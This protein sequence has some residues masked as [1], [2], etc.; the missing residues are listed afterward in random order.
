MP[1]PS[2]NYS[3]C[4][5]FR[6]C[7]GPVWPRRVRRVRPPHGLLEAGPVLSPGGPRGPVRAGARPRCPDHP[8]VPADGELDLRVHPVPVQPAGAGALEGPPLDAV[9]S[10]PLP[11]RVADA[12][13]PARERQAV[14]TRGAGGGGA[15][16]L[17]QPLTGTHS[18]IPLPATCPA[19]PP[20]CPRRSLLRSLRSQTRFFATK[21]P[22]DEPSY[23]NRKS[24]LSPGVEVTNNRHWVPSRNWSVTLPRRSVGESE[25]C[26]WAMCKR[27]RLCVRASRLRDARCSLRTSRL[28]VLVPPPSTSSAAPTRSAPPRSTNTT[29]TRPACTTTTPTATPR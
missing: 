22:K 13:R 26:V 8:D 16:H 18:P 10:V 1:R 3:L 25:G 19:R 23:G 14:S 9:R 5:C 4:L 27:E 29:A 20:A 2:V 24:V 17:R 11:R 21:T 7:S 28:P 15:R 6:Q 12:A